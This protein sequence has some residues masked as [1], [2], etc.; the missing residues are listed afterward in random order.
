MRMIEPL[1]VVLYFPEPY[2]FGETRLCML[3]QALAEHRRA[4]VSAEGRSR[5]RRHVC[6]A[7]T[8]FRAVETM[9]V[10]LA[11]GLAL[12]HDLMDEVTERLPH[13][14]FVIVGR[15]NPDQA[16]RISSLM[17]RPNVEVLGVVDEET[18]RS[19]LLDAGVAPVPFKRDE[20][21]DCINPTK[22]YEYASYGIPIVASATAEARQLPM[23][24]VAEDPASFAEAIESALTTP[25]PSSHDLLTFAEQNTWATRAS[26]LDR[27]LR[28]RCDPADSRQLDA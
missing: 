6:D 19:C 3:P 21:G 23:V 24:T 22:V 25:V 13:R 18:K 11:S 4:C 9:V 1:P 26:A 17:K 10:D 16:S 28:D 2:E 15:V 8:W 7:P 12:H 27:V 20:I 14:E 5:G